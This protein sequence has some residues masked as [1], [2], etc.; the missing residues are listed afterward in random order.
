LVHSSKPVFGTLGAHKTCYTYLSYHTNEVLAELQKSH[1]IPVIDNIVMGHDYLSAYLQ[2]N[3]KP[4]DIVLS[5]S[6][7]GAQL[8]EKKQSDCWIY[9]WV[10]LNL[11]LDKRYHKVNVLPGGFIPGP[12][13]PK[14]LHSFLFTGRHHLAALQ[15]EGLQIWDAFAKETY[16]S[17]PYLMFVTS[18]GPG[19]VH[20]DGMVGQSGTNGCRLYCG[21]LSHHKGGS[22]H[23]YPALLMPWDHSS[24]VEWSNHDNIDVF[25]LPSSG[26]ENYTCNLFVLVSSP[27]PR[28]FDLRKTQTGITKPPLILGLNPS[29]SLRIPLSAI[30]NE[31]L[32]R[33]TTSYVKIAFI[34]FDPASIR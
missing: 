30:G 15:N 17:D 34:L 19:L 16:Q 29:W 20:L 21:A 2:G 23:Y 4:R 24:C 10:I 27:N 14:N 6:L 25:N 3:I 8:Y 26:H 28:Q 11:S 18:D 9:I 33:S 32:K 7:D 22:T 1:T 5:I 31:S 12:N 13:K